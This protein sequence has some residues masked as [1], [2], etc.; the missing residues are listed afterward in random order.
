MKKLTVLIMPTFDTTRES[1]GYDEDED[2]DSDA[3]L[4]QQGYDTEAIEVE[5]EESFQ[6]PEG[7][8]GRIA[9]EDDEDDDEEAD[10][11]KDSKL[12]LIYDLKNLEVKHEYLL[13]GDLEEGYYTFLAQH[14]AI[15]M[16]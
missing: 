4:F 12:Y 7:F 3:I 1:A 10:E 8:T 15:L 16:D 9:D 6:I 14:N 5:D 13:E 2:Y 11:N